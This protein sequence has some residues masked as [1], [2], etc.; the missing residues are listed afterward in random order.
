MFTLEQVVGLI[1]H[2]LVKNV[3][4]LHFLATQSSDE[5][6]RPAQLSWRQSSFAK[7]HKFRIHQH[8]N[9]IQSVFIVDLKSV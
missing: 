2:A 5:Q 4:F 7:C 1:I 6:H 8:L 9:I 3:Q